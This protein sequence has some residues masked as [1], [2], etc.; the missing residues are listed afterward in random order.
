MEHHLSFKQRKMEEIWRSPMTKALI[1]TEMWNV[2]SDNTK[3]PPKSS[4]TRWLRTE[5]GRLVGVTTA[6]QL[7]WLTILLAQPSYS[8]QQLCTVNIEIFAWELFSRF[9]LLCKNYSHAKIK[10]IC[11]YEGNMSSIVKITPTWNVL[12]TFSW[13]FPPAKITTFTVIQRM[14]I[15][16]L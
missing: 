2:Q 8:M 15:K 9:S 5:L 14:H 7:M 12:S 3:T 6:T 16:N 4:I 1:P 10:L 11:L 13:D